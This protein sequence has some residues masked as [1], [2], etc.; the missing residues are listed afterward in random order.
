MGERVDF[1][2]ISTNY[3]VLFV[4]TARKTS[5]ILIGDQVV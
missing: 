4:L 2:M 1:R 5:F 3:D